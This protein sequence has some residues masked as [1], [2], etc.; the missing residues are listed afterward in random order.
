MITQ[1]KEI[2]VPEYHKL[3][4]ILNAHER[5][6]WVPDEA[7]MRSD[8]EQWKNGKISESEKAFIKMILR[9]F[10]QADT[11]VCSAYVNRL[12]PIFKHPDA[13]TMLLSFA[14]RE[15]TLLVS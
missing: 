3:Q 6:H 11:D 12:L 8:V 13:R 2:F 9:L 15:V 10:T 7:D 14:N 4:E 1:A 5:A